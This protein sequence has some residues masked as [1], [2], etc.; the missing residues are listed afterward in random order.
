MLYDFNR[1]LVVLFLVGV[2]DQVSLRQSTE[3]EERVGKQM[4]QQLVPL[5]HPWR[6]FFNYVSVHL[7]KSVD[8]SSVHVEFC[9]LVSVNLT[10]FGDLKGLVQTKRCLRGQAAP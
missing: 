1:L 8:G 9:F 6:F 7:H 10:F 4:K 2:Q 5:V 3:Q